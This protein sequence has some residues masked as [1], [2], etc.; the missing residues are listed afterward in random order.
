MICPVC[1]HQQEFGL[2]CDNCGKDLGGLLGIMGPPPSSVE[3]VEGLEQTVAA[4]VGELAVERLGE[5]E[6]TFFESVSVNPAPV[7]GAEATAQEAVGD[8]SV[9]RMGELTED[10]VLDNGPKTA[11]PVGAVKCRYC[12]NLQASGSLCERCGM[13]LP[14][15]AAAAA[16]PRTAPAAIAADAVRCRACGAPAQP[17]ARCRECGKETPAA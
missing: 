9:E 10:R 12:G 2:E 5:L 11:A 1:E 14:K 3:V 15:A 16:A 17:G 4:S 7:E 8:V 13:R 6:V